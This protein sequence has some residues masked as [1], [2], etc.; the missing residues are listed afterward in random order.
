MLIPYEWIELANRRWM[1]LQEE[2]F[3]PKGKSCR[4]GADV[5]GMGRDSSVLC[6][7]YGSY[8]SEFDVHDSAGTADHMH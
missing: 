1:K 5:A 2:R 6:S 4:I 3:Q 8:V 7:R